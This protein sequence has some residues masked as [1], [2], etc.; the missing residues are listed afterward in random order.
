MDD[1]A[2]KKSDLERVGAVTEI[3]TKVLAIVVTLAA[4][5]G[6]LLFGSYCVKIRAL[7]EADLPS[8]MQAIYALSVIGVIGF[9]LLL[10]GMLVPGFLLWTTDVGK[11]TRPLDAE[12]QKAADLLG[13][14]RTL[15]LIFAAAAGQIVLC[16]Y[17]LIFKATTLWFLEAFAISI[18]VSL[19]LFRFGSNPKGK[20][21]ESTVLPNRE[22]WVG[23]GITFAFLNFV[24][25]TAFAIRY[26]QSLG[27]FQLS[28]DPDAIFG[29]LI[30]ITLFIAV[31]FFAG[32]VGF[33][34][35]YL[36]SIYAAFVVG[37]CLILNLGLVNPTAII[38]NRLS[39]GALYHE[40]LLVTQEG[41][42]ILSKAGFPLIGNEK[43]GFVAPDVN[44]LLRMGSSYLLT[45][46]ATNA[47]VTIPAT[48]VKAFSQ[49]I[50]SGAPPVL[51]LDEDTVKEE[52]S[53]IA[54][55]TKGTY[56]NATSSTVSI[57][58][59]SDSKS[60][61]QP[62]LNRLLVRT[63]DFNACNLLL[64]RPTNAQDNSYRD[65]ITKTLASNPDNVVLEMSA[66]STDS[67]HDAVVS[68]TGNKAV[69]N[70]VAIVELL[71]DYGLRNVVISEAS[72][73]TLPQP[74]GQSLTIA[75]HPSWLLEPDKDSKKL[76]EEILSRYALFQSA[77]S[78]MVTK[79]DKA[80]PVSKAP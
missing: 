76:T 77:V 37:L 19:L 54:D 52:I 9:G 5:L 68:A 80:K 74:Q 73:P 57:A 43:T 78:A 26:W 63:A 1:M 12:A 8:L 46:S 56:V 44:I 18:A 3:V 59:R 21:P 6:F 7:P 72:S 22:A 28:S 34:R 60:S 38:L 32:I 65:A 24:S 69:T 40:S 67:S 42:E 70:A 39:L 10:I 27:K 20:R 23:L 41:A 53:K 55:R 25:G 48:L 2:E 36:F 58:S 79:L 49:T 51:E 4:G 75:I 35:Q 31:N 50:A 45:S 29:G 66:L 13:I 61:V 30:L 11:V 64:G 33:A 15:R 14:R 71:R 62:A 47:R 17:F 16:G